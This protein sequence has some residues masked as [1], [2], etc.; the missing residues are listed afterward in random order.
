LFPPAQ[1]S[2]YTSMSRSKLMFSAELRLTVTILTV[3]LTV[4]DSNGYYSIL[5]PI[6]PHSIFHS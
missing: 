1:K 4:I 2:L 3:I 5:T 6:F